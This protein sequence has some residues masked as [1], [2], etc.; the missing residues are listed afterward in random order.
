[1][2]CGAEDRIGAAVAF[3]K[4]AVTD[5]IAPYNQK[6][7][8]LSSIF[9]CDGGR[10]MCGA[11]RVCAISLCLVSTASPGVGGAPRRRR[12]VGPAQLRG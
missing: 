5:P 7:S 12:S 10:R 11:P 4:V 2:G 9:I 1:M 8:L 3:P 6:Y